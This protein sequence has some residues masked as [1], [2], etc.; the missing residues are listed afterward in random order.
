[1]SVLSVLTTFAIVSNFM[2]DK[3][4]GT[5]QVPVKQDLV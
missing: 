4:T 1:M 3:K 5:G 2:P